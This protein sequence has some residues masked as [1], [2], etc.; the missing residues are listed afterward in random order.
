MKTA[1]INERRQPG[2]FPYYKIQWRDEVIQAWRDIQQRFQSPPDAIHEASNLIVPG[3]E[4]RLMEVSEHGR[5][6]WQC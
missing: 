6:V 3:V 1:H 2:Y 5:K 4:W